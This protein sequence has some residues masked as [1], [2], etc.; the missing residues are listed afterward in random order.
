MTTR[1]VRVGIM[2]FAHVH[3]TAYASS[4]KKLD[5]VEFVGVADENPTRAKQMA[6]A[7]G[8]Q[9][10]KSYEDMLASD[11][12]AV[13]VTSEN[14]NHRKHVVTAAQSEKHVLC[15][16]PLATSMEDAEAIVE[17]CRRSRVEL[18][19]ALPCRFHPAFTRLKAAVDAGDFGKLLAIKSTNQGQC[20][21]LWFTDPK[22][23]G[24]GAVIDHT[25]HLVD[26]M[27]FLI[28]AEVAT[29]YAEV[30]DKLLGCEVEDSGIITVEFTNKVFASI[31][32]S[33][34]RPKKS[35][36]TWGN[37]N[38][39]ITGTNGVGRLTMFAQK[40]D[41]YSEKAGKLSYEYWG[42]DIG[43]ELVSSFV[44][45][46]AQDKTVA[47]TGNDGLKATEIALAAYRSAKTGEAI[48][49]LE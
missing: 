19:V 9:M 35:Y 3:A 14:A 26:L 32:C 37:L 36:P 15:E 48:N 8:V 20:P 18:M 11:I 4:L 7:F 24:G 46:I 43:T 29:V 39:D 42:D 40:I 25:V 27:R 16:K 49:L 22:L 1:P 38:M 5:S 13:V 12:D 6:K 23:A 17:V 44:E 10:F 45:S 47:I 30:G 2:S 21:G 41:L 33:W 28:G 34:S 31:D